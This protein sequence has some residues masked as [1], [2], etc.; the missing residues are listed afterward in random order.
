MEFHFSPLLWMDLLVLSLSYLQI[1]L[2][3][4]VPRGYNIGRW[5]QARAGPTH[6]VP[7]YRNNYSKRLRCPQAE[8]QASLLMLWENAPTGNKE[9]R[10]FLS[11]LTTVEWLP[12]ILFL[13]QWVERLLFYRSTVGPPWPIT[14]PID[15]RRPG[16]YLSYHQDTGHNTESCR[17]LRALLAG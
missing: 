11:I 7:Y 4:T 14:R 16:R 10:L 3:Y 8:M 5:R 15:K 13:P 9:T 17:E 6:Q 2:N 12:T 1:Q